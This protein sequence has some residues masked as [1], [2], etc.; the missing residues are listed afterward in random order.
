MATAP[1]EILGA[2]V[3][4]SFFRGI[5]RKHHVQFCALVWRVQGYTS[6]TSFILKGFCRL[7]DIFAYQQRMDTAS[8]AFQYGTTIWP[9]C[10]CYWRWNDCLWWLHWGR[11][12]FLN[13]YMD[14]PLYQS[15]LDSCVPRITQLFNP[16]TALSC[17]DSHSFPVYA[18]VFPFSTV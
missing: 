13:R 1:G 15:H 11:T 7:L 5:C 12:C 8:S 9:L 4:C 17:Q 10:C 18:L 6:P 16:R 14:L 3:A 2:K